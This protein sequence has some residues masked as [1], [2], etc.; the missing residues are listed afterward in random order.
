MSSRTVTLVRP[1]NRLVILRSPASGN[2][3]GGGGGGAVSAVNGEIGDVVLDAADVG[4]DP[5]G[6]ADALMLAHAAEIGPGKHLP[7]GGTTGE[8]LQRSA[9]SPGAAWVPV[10]TNPVE[11]SDLNGAILGYLRQG[12]DGEYH[13][14]GAGAPPAGVCTNVVYEGP[15]DPATSD[16]DR[17]V[18]DG[19]I[20]LTTILEP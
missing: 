15:D 6:T 19:D 7:P 2:G 4:A 10:P 17:A 8:Y 18:V 11:W 12:T 16:T 5:E 20:W 9:G 13:W 1:Q 3:G 14:P